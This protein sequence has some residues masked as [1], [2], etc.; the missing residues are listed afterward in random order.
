MCKL[1]VDIFI[2]SI[3]GQIEKR[4]LQGGGKG[5][6]GR[7]YVI[8]FEKGVSLGDGGSQGGLGWLECSVCKVMGL[9]S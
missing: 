6:I 7:K 3:Q 9:E 2:R 5:D 1:R 4:E 8:K